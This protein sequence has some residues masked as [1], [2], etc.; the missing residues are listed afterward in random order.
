IPVLALATF[1]CLFTGLFGLLSSTSVASKR[2][3]PRLKDAIS[4]LGGGGM[5]AAE[6]DAI[7]PSD[8]Q[9]AK[10]QPSAPQG[11]LLV[12]SAAHS[13]Q[14]P[15]EPGN[16]KFPLGIGARGQLVTLSEQEVGT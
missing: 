16:R 12:T 3:P 1:V 2:L 15:Q 10:L 13:I 8:E 11:G 9:V 7:V 5:A 4:P 14:E 6:L